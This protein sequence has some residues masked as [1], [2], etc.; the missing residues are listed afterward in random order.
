MGQVPGDVSGVARTPSRPHDHVV[1]REPLSAAHGGRPE[2]GQQGRLAGREE[3]DPAV[4]FGLT[5]H[6]GRHDLVVEP[7]ART[8]HRVGERVVPDL[9][10]VG[11]SVPASGLMAL[12][13]GDVARRSS[14]ARKEPSGVVLRG[15]RVSAVPTIDPPES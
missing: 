11:S 5:P 8:R 14:H 7:E 10:T 2:A 1:A 4:C 6:G 12:L 15:N 13:S 9:D 3:A